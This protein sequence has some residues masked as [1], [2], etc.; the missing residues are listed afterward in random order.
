MKVSLRTLVLNGHYIV[1]VN[2]GGIR[3]VHY[4]NSISEALV[5]V[6]RTSKELGIT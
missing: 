4:C 5:L 6:E 2:I 1:E 3:F